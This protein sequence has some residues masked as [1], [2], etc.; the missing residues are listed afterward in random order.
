MVRSE[1]Y[2]SPDG[3]PEYV[4]H[5]E[6]L[7]VGGGMLAPLDAI[8]SAARPED[9]H[10]DTLGTIW[11]AVTHI[12]ATRQEPSVPAVARLLEEWGSLEEVGGEPRLVLLAGDRFAF[13]YAGKAALEA[14]AGI[15]AEWGAKR[16]EIARLADEIRS[17][18]SGKVIPSAH[19]FRGG[20]SFDYVEAADAQ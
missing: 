11:N 4:I 15:V 7:L 18:T 3:T 16:R 14:H 8:P 1:R 20:V 10:D 13:L 19:R 5:T 2:I 6:Q 17:V 9:F 12:A